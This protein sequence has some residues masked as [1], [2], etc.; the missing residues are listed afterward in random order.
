[1]NEVSA[2]AVLSNAAF[3]WNTVR[4]TDPILLSDDPFGSQ[5]DAGGACRDAYGAPHG[6]EDR[7]RVL[8]SHIPPWTF[9]GAP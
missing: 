6:E 1:M 5:P 3:V 7:A 9:R 8:R 4:M 2:L